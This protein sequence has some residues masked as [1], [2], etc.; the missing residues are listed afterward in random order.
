MGNSEVI[1]ERDC[2]QNC[3]TGQMQETREFKSLKRAKR[4]LKEPSTYWFTELELAELTS[5]DKS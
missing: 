4:E 5:K 2:Q 3:A 1:C